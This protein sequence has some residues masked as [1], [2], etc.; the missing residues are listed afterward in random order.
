MNGHGPAENDPR[1]NDPLLIAIKCPDQSHD[2]GTRSNGG[3]ISRITF[4]LR[5]RDNKRTVAR[6]IL[7]ILVGAGTIRWVF[8]FPPSSPTTYSL[9]NTWNCAHAFPI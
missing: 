8:S 1:A 4:G 5:F 3:N 2:T 7:A 9:Y 6:P